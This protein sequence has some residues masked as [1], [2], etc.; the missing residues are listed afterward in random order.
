MVEESAAPQG[1]STMTARLERN[2]TKW[3]RRGPSRC[4]LHC[5]SAGRPGGVSTGF[6]RYRGRFGQCGVVARRCECERRGGP[7]IANR[8]ARQLHLLRN[9]CFLGRRC[10]RFLGLLPI[11]PQGRLLGSRARWFVL[12]CKIS[13]LCA[14]AR[15]LR[16]YLDRQPVLSACPR[17]RR[18]RKVRRPVD[19]CAQPVLGRR[20]RGDSRASAA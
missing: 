15:A 4:P 11:D 2:S 14:F 20:L 13:K 6:V 18:G 5:T 12:I 19:F 10:S 17:G 7:Q 1:R 8:A 16:R 3:A 9:Q